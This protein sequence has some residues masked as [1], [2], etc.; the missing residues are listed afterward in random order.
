MNCFPNKDGPIFEN[1][2]LFIKLAVGIFIKKLGTIFCSCSLILYLY[3]YINSDFAI[4]RG[5]SQYFGLETFASIKGKT[6]GIV[7]V[8]LF[9]FLPKLLVPF[10]VVPFS[11]VRFVDRLCCVMVSLLA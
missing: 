2:R 6:A 4:T 8:H 5:C 1:K 10:M 7:K 9:L 11:Y 3:I